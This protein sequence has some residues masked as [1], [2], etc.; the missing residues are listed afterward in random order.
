MK[1]IQTG[2]GREYEAKFLHIDVNKTRK[3]IKK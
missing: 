1:R 2:S 3:L